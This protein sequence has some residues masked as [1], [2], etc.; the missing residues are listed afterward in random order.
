MMMDKGNLYVL[1]TKTGVIKMQQDKSYTGTWEKGYVEL[2]KAH[3]PELI[4]SR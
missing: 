1:D 2:K 4:P 3:E